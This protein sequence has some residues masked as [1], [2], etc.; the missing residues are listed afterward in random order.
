M[1]SQSTPRSAS[2]VALIVSLCLNLLLAG[3]IV[4]ALVRFSVFHPMFGSGTSGDFRSGS[5]MGHGMWQ[6]E[7]LSPHA[8]MNAAPGKAAQIRS[9]IDAHRTKIHDLRMS[10]FDA[11]NEALRLLAA[12][13][14]DRSAFDRSLSKLQGADAALEAEVLKTVSESAAA[15]TPEERRAAASA[16]AKWGHGHGHGHG[17]GG[18]HGW[19]GGRDS[20]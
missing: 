11:R 10:S 3:V 19:R 9:I 2:N 18:H 5:G 12:P 15:L 20:P 14:F 13:E 17:R 1:S 7:P 16:P 4:T 6:M 8:M